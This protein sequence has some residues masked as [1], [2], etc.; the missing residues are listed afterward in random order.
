MVSEKMARSMPSLRRNL[1]SNLMLWQIIRFPS[2]M[3]LSKG[4]TPEG[5]RLR[6]WL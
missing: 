2:K 3:G 5:S 4:K 6:P 1:K